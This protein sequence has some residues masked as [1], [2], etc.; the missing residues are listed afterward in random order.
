[1]KKCTVLKIFNRCIYFLIFAPVSPN[2]IQTAKLNMHFA[3]QCYAN[4]L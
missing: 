2:R 4:V 3:D 1:M